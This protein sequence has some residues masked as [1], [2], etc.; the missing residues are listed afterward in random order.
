MYKKAFAVGG[1]VAM[2]L[3]VS[4]AASAAVTNPATTTF[5]VKLTIQPECVVG[6]VTDLDFGSTGF[7]TTNIDVQTAINV[8]C[9]KGTVATVKLDNG[10][11]SGVNCVGSAR[12]L[13]AGTSSY[14]NYELYTD[15]ARTN[16]WTS[17]LAT[18]QTGNGTG[19]SSGGTPTK[20]QT[21]TVYGRVPAT[22]SGYAPGAY[23][24]TVTVN[25]SF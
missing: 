3:G 8:G 20:D 18:Q 17:T 1:V 16:P 15:F 12:C 11:N 21:L 13:K 24:D 4:L 9:T 7:I 14:I 19:A 6:A 2:A 25:V 23:T 5:A 22:N 10:V